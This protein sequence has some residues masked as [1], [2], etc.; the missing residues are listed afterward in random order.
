MRRLKLK[1][2]FLVLAWSAWATVIAADMAPEG[3]GEEAEST[4]LP[5]EVQAVLDEVLPAEAYTDVTRC[6]RGRQVRRVEILDDKHVLMFGSHGRAWLN[7]LHNRCRGIHPS[8]MLMFDAW[9]TKLCHLDFVRA[10]DR[11]RDTFDNFRED[12]MTGGYATRCRLGKFE[13]M[14]HQQAET[15]LEAFRTDRDKPQS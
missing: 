13:E 7:R 6:V 1:S 3:D 4:E 10:R 5:K 9:G 11:R 8:M 12:A 14:T 2:V 15:V